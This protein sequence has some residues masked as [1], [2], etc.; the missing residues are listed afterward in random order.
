MPQYQGIW[1]LAQ[2][3]QLQSTQQWVK[4]P[5]YN[6]TTLLLQADN[7]A[8]GAQNNTFLDSSSN[9]FTITRNGNTTQGS[10]SPFSQ[11]GWGNYFPGGNGKYISAPY[12]TA[13]DFGTNDFSVECFA[14]VTDAG[15]SYDA[16]KYGTFVSGGNANSLVNLWGFSFLISGGVINQLF[17]DANGSTVLTASSQ[18][19]S[20]N[21]WHHFVV[22]RT[23]TALSIYSDGTRVATTTYSSAVNTN[24]SGAVR[25]SQS[26]FE[27][28][29]ENWLIGYISNVRIIKGTQPYNAANSSI[30]V[31]T[32]H[33]T[34]ITNTSLLTCLSNRFIDTGT[35]NGGNPF[36]ITIVG[37]GM[38]IQAFSPFAPQYQYTPS[39]TGGSGYFDGGASTYLTTSNATAFDFGTGDFTIECWAYVTAQTGSFTLLC[40]TE[41]VNEYWG[42]G[43]VGSTGM[44]MYA[45]SPGTDIYSGSGSIPSLNQWN[46]LVWQR[47]SGV[48]SMYLNGIRVYNAS[49]TA[50]FGS[51]ATGFRIGQSANYANYYTTG[52]ISN[53]R[54]VKGSGVYS[55]STITVPTAPP[56][57]ITNT[58][59][60]CNFTNAGIYDGTL[61]NNLETVGNAQVSTSVV[62]YG[63]GSMYFD[64]TGDWLQALAVSN[65]LFRFGTNDFTVE[66]W[67]Y[68]SSTSGR[69]DLLGTY[70]ATPTGWG[71]GTTISTTA[72]VVFYIGNTALAS[73]SAS[74]WSVSTWTHVAVVRLN[75]N[76]RIYVNGVS[77]ASVTNTTNLVVGSPLQV[78]AAGNSTQAYNGYI[79]DLRI[80]KGIARYT[81][82][83][84]PPRVALPR[85]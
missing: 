42:F 49:Y 62:K 8:N 33:L 41:G 63:T 15:R 16:N 82:N 68:R 54:V 2:A 46:H 44:T 5:L 43:S 9:N 56:T 12:N 14:Y 52:Y 71:L 64:G 21:A 70:S 34:N 28:V 60:L 20:L 39:V 51:T 18:S 24:S 76:L 79:D 25:I 17:F 31:P 22:C 38:S 30:T 85:Q 78:G 80:T 77:Q 11:T 61:K 37:T 4:D 73:T 13:F 45:G 67:F 55:G 53:L 57:A 35:A 27:N 10:F 58:Q 81:A 50:D 3:A 32:A 48:A 66:C 65:E 47:S 69:G 26:A 83:F 84:T 7:A 29:F 1:T 6:S 36:T 75:N 59:L 40:A 74:A 19:I 72:D 23:G